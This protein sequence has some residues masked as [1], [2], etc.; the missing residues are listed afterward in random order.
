VQRHRIAPEH[1]RRLERLR[2][3]GR[4]EVAAARLRGIADDRLIL[5]GRKGE[6]EVKPPLALGLLADA[7]DQVAPRLWA[8]GALTKGMYWEMTAVPDIRAQAERVAT[9]I[10]KELQQHG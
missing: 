2:G 7:E 3:E 8:L 4:L 9:A 10:V 6:R 1:A 5:S